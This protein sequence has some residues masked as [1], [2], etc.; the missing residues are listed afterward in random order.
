MHRRVRMLRKGR[1]QKIMQH[2]KKIIGCVFLNM[3]LRINSYQ[4]GAN[5]AWLR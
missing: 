5:M 4:S 2:D 3:A 1:I